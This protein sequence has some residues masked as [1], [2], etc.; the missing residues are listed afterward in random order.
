MDFKSDPEIVSIFLSPNALVEDST[1]I[2]IKY[3]PSNFLDDPSMNAPSI[4]ALSPP[5]F[6]FES[7]ITTQR[8]YDE[9]LK[10]K[11]VEQT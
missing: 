11:K 10:W 5:N 4:A 8:K 1:A 7:F 3:S 2:P 9:S 6:S